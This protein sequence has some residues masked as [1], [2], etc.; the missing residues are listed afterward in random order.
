LPDEKIGRQRKEKKGKKKKKKKQ[1][2]A[3]QLP[4]SREYVCGAKAQNPVLESESIPPTPSP[5]S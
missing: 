3:G 1:T 2:K 5:L 4:I